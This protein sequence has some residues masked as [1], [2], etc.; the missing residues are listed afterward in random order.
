MIKT[1][2]IAL[3][4][5]TLTN[6]ANNTYKVKKEANTEGRV[7]NQVPQWYVDAKIDKGFI[8]NKDADKYVYAVGQ[9]RS[10][11]IQLAIEKAMM[12]AKAELADKL[13]GQ[14]NKRTDLYITEIGT[15]GNKKIVSKI[16]ETIVNVVKATMI[17]GYEA[18]EKAV[19]ETPD[20]EYRVYVGLKM[21][22]GETNKLA[23]YIAANA[24]TA[25]DVDTLAKNAI[26]KV[27]INDLGPVGTKSN[28]DGIKTKN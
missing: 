6:C 12:I 24:I 26:Q 13:R 8:F 9:G 17:Q 28:P 14:M 10:T 20:N 3:L 25:V 1:I 5:L 16:E 27:M 18:W 23:E 4:A 22:V 21:G 15:D 2:M 11:D 19:Y 7:L